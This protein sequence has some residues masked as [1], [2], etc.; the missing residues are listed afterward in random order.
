MTVSDGDFRMTLN[1]TVPRDIN[2]VR[3][4]HVMMSMTNTGSTSGCKSDS[5]THAG[6]E[7]NKSG[8]SSLMNIIFSCPTVASSVPK[9]HFHDSSAFRKP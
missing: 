4:G 7:L 8:L 3:I 5:V 6:F 2:L 9:S 1:A